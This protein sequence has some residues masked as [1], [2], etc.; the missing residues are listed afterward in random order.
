MFSMKDFREQF[1]ILSKPLRSGEPLIYLDNAATTQKPRVVVDAIVDFYSNYNSNVHRGGYEFGEIATAKYEQTRLAI[2]DYFGVKNA[3]EIVFVRGTTEAINLVAYSYC[4]NFLSAGDEI[5]VGA[6]EHHANYLPWQALEREIGT[7]RKIIPLDKDYKIDVAKYENL[8]SRKTKFVAVQHINNVL[9]TVNDV[10]AL[11]KIA[12]G[13]GAKILVDGANAMGVGG[14]DL[15]EMDCDFFACSGHKGFGPTG[16][17]FLFGKYEILQTMPPF[18]TGGNTVNRV[19]FDETSFKLPPD[20]FEAGTPDIAAIIGLGEAVAFLKKMDW[21]SARTH[22]SLLRIRA[23]EGL[24]TVSGIEIYGNTRYPS[25]VLSFNLRGI[26]AHDVATFLGHGGIAV[27][28]GT[29]C[30]QPLMD[31]LGVPGTIRISLCPYNTV[32]EIDTAISSM[33]KCRKILGGKLG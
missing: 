21:D 27:R 8:F 9:G 3:R 32:D 24:R 10:G 13:N 31:I 7:V 25:D 33:E 14:I 28:A 26:H 19:R 2:A 4:R 12:H 20:K 29:H 17:G 22:M 11:C 5:L 18:H 15:H 23:S 1:P 30:A 6:A 16:S